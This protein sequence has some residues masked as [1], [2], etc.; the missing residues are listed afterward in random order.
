MNGPGRWLDPA[1]R[2]GAVTWARERLAEHGRTLTGPAEQPHVRPWST[3]L[4]LPTDDGPV[5]LKANGPGTSYEASLLEALGCWAPDRVLV[6]L[7]VDAG[8][9]WLL[10]PDGG[11]TM[12]GIVGPGGK[13]GCWE[14]LLPEYADLQRKLAPLVD[15]MVALGVPDL[16]PARLPE[17]L[18]A[19]LDDGDA[20]LLDRPGGMTVE[21]LGQLREMQPEYAEWCAQLDES[22]VPPS[23]QHDDLHD[24]NVFVRG[25]AYLIFD[26]GDAVVSHPFASL[27]IVL[28]SV[29]MRLGLGPGASELG[30]LRDAY[31]EAW[32]G[33]HDRTSLIETAELAMRLAAVSRALAWQRA[34]SGVDPADRGTDAGAV[35]SWLA[36]LV[37]YEPL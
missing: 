37:D 24:N 4:K 11:Q 31:L 13:L 33:E 3:V 18:A 6:P 29:A 8:R 2:D 23:L 20:L 35:A 17:H 21:T 26:W 1:W 34:L 28:G 36:E 15:D 14:R 16:R 30:R 22:G 25:D 19:L 9:G 12:R 27:R 10:L 5:W 7:A 32:T